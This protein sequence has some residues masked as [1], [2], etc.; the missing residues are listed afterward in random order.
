[1]RIIYEG[2]ITEVL[3]R[4]VRCTIYDISSSNKSEH[5]EMS[6]DQFP[7]YHKLTE[8]TMFLLTI[9]D[10][11]NTK[12][13]QIKILKPKPLSQSQLKRIR[14]EAREISAALFRQKD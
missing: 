8:G 11:G 9:T 6:V 12:T 5:V 3:R 10:E 2:I 13:S 7:A 14:K 4:Y 1:M